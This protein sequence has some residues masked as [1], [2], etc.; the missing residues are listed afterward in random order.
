MVKKLF[1]I[2]FALF[3]LI[4]AAQADTTKVRTEIIVVSGKLP[5]EMFTA[6]F[7]Q[8]E[9]D[10]VFIRGILKIGDGYFEKIAAV[11]D[12]LEDVRYLFVVVSP[13]PAN[14]SA[15]RKRSAYVIRTRF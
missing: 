11:M 8:A 13:A 4:A 14:L 9:A 10:S 5:R 15:A 3:P 1:L 2:A 12:E 6:N 7:Q